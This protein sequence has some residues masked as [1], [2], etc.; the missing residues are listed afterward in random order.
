MEEKLYQQNDYK[1]CI[2]C[3]D[4]IKGEY[5]TS[6]KLCGI[7]THNECWD[8]WIDQSKKYNRCVH[9]GQKNC[10]YSK[11]LPWLWRLIYCIFPFLDKKNKSI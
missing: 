3:F 8:D 4:K 7:S 6:C 11:K 10:M 2:I 1:E 9:C 5:R